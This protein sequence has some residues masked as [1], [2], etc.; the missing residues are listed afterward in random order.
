MFKG[1]FS[2]TPRGSAVR[3]RHRPPGRGVAKP[4]GLPQKIR[5]TA[6][7]AVTHISSWRLL[8][9]P[10]RAENVDFQGTGIAAPVTTQRQPFRDPPC[11][12][13]KIGGRSVECPDLPRARERAAP[14]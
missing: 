6:H 7:G 13:E 9:T 10:L 5:R 11:V 2:F 12:Q 3:V 8:P 1:A 4:S 14:L